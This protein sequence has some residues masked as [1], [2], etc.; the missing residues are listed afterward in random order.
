[1]AASDNFAYNSILPEDSLQDQ[2]PETVKLL[3]TLANI[4][5]SSST[6]ISI[7]IT[8]DQFQAIY[9]KLLESTSSSPS[10]CH[11]GHYKLV[12]KSDFLSDLYSKMMS[13]PLLAG[14]SP[15]KWREVMDMMLEKTSGDPKIHRLWIIALQETDFNQ[16]NRLATSRPLL[17]KLG[18]A[19]LISDMQYG[20]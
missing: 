5:P 12:A 16:C 15:S 4:V 1:M 11:I 13:I 2:L 14:F 17:Y 7:D 10:R 20:S 19:G 3:Q 6:D 9:S 18:D 8:A